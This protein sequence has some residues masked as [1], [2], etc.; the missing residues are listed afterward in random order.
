MSLSPD[1]DPTGRGGLLWR[2]KLE[3]KA[4]QQEQLRISLE[5]EEE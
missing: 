2:L 1:P 5:M 4:G 3:T